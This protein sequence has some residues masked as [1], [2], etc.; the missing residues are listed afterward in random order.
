MNGGIGLALLGVVGIVALVCLAS[1][2]RPV[3]T[4]QDIKLTAKPAP[5]RLSRYE[6]WQKQFSCQN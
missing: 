5:E 2:R 4:S 3:G 6:F 1:R